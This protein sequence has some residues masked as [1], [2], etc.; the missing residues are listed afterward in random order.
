MLFRSI[1]LKK[2]ELTHIA[3]VDFWRM[4]SLA[5]R[6]LEVV[7]V[8]GHE[9]CPN[10]DCVIRMMLLRIKVAEIDAHG[11]AEVGKQGDQ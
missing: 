1:A 2:C 9:H 4:L 10:V 11:G 7:S 3:D 8:A 6:L 5:P